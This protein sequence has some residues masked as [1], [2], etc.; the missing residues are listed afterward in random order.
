MQ[1]V[2]ACSHSPPI[3]VVLAF[4]LVSAWLPVVGLVVP[5]VVLVPSGCVLCRLCLHV[6]S[7]M[8]Q[9]QFSQIG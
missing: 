3:V 5:F 4:R 1:F 6:H 2:C 9:R 7:S 8:A